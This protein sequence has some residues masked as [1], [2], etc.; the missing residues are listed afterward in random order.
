LIVER[1]KLYREIGVDL[2]LTAFLHFN[3]ELEEFGHQVIS[4]FKRDQTKVTLPVPDRRASR[5]PTIPG[6]DAFACGYETAVETRK[7]Q[8]QAIASTEQTVT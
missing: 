7:A 3:D 8:E 1:I 4:Q 5:E 6:Q 2:L